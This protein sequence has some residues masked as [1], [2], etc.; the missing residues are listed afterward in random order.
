[1]EN[2]ENIKTVTQSVSELLHLDKYRTELEKIIQN[3]ELRISSLETSTELRISSLE[4]NMELMLTKNTIVQEISN[5]V[6][7]SEEEVSEQLRRIKEENERTRKELERNEIQIETNT[8][9][10]EVQRYLIE[11]M[12]KK[13]NGC[14]VNEEVIKELIQQEFTKKYL[15]KIKDEIE[16]NKKENSNPPDN[17][18]MKEQL[19]NNPINKPNNTVA[20]QPHNVPIIYP[21]ERTLD[22]KYIKQLEE[23]T[24]RKVFNILFDSDKDDWNI[25]TSVFKQRIMNK[26]HLIIIIED[27]EGNKFGGYVNSRINR[28]ESCIYDSKSFVFSLESNG[29]MKGM[30][31]FDIKQPRFAFWL[32]NQSSDCLFGIGFSDIRVYKEN[33]KTKSFCIQQYSYEYEGISNTLCG[34]LYPDRFTPK[35]I[36]VIEMK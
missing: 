20:K 14:T 36:I 9:N 31:K 10:I 6:N 23:W 17:N 24:N 19:E 32:D 13:M 33:D 7:G 26:E 22:T 8:L 25:N 30:M 3:Q 34:K 11:E 2:Q 18:P 29:R 28:V 4:T 5:T 35:R 15:Q 21:I 27:E 1:M 16:K 12:K